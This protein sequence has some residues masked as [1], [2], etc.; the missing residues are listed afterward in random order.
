MFFGHFSSPST[1]IECD[2]GNL[3]ARTSEYFTCILKFIKLPSDVIFNCH[4]PGVTKLITRLR[5]GLIHLRE[6]KFKQIFQDTLSPI[7]SCG[8][9]IH[10]SSNTFFDVLIIQMKGG[11]S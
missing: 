3:N 5:L 1:V 6:H 7:C 10:A 9:Y 2:N 4:S 8:D 11:H